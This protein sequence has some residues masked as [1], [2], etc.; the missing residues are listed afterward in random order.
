M[1]VVSVNVMRNPFTPRD[2]EQGALSGII[3]ALIVTTTY[4]HVGSGAIEP[5]LEESARRIDLGWLLRKLAGTPRDFEELKNFFKQRGALIEEVMTNVVYGGRVCI[6]GSTI[7]GLLRARLELTPSK[8]GVAVSCMLAMTPPL[9]ELPPRGVHGWRHARIWRE[10]VFENRGS[11]CNPIATGD[12][13]V[14]KV[15]DLFGAPGLVGRV[16]PSNFCCDLSSCERKE[17][18][19]GEG[20]IERI[21]AIKPGTVLEGSI[22]F[23]SL[24]LDELGALFVAMGLRRGCL[25]G[26]ELLIGKHKYMFRDM[27]VAKFRL[28][29]IEFPQRFEDVLRSVGI[30][31]ERQG[32]RIVCKDEALRKLV[33]LAIDDA[34]SRY[35]QL[36]W[37]HDFSE[38]ERKREVAS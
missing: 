28:E 29:S 13:T 25:E 19:F 11:S 20:K 8:D 9:T 6:P 23:T 14:C 17:F 1:S 18:S 10:S 27:G 4:V 26:R 31:C 7:K 35:P 12:Y 30:D 38:V 3:N 33:D 22:S 32:Y 37:L 5:R 24:T 36:R 15:C 2:V 21:L 34:L 16:Y